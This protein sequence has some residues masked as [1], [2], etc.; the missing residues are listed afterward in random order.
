MVWI[1]G[2]TTT[3]GGFVDFNNIP[4]TFTHLQI[5][6]FGASIYTSGGSTGPLDTWIGLNN[7]S[8]TSF[9]NGYNH[10]LQGDGTSAS[11]TGFAQGNLLNVGFLPFGFADTFVGSH[12]IDILDYTNTNKNKVIR[13]I[14]GYDA[15]GS[16]IVTLYSGL[17]LLTA[18]VSQ[19]RVAQNAG[20]FRAGNRID[21]YGITTSSVTGA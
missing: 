16:G 6:M 1:A 17:A 7:Q 2:Q 18:T 8:G 20:G 14:G 4:Q 3:A 10:R 12:I 13:S 11:S 5:R 21:L 9:T 15:N 19:I